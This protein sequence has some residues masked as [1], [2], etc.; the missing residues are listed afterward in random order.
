MHEGNTSIRFT[1][2]GSLN[3]EIE[4]ENDVSIFNSIANIVNKNDAN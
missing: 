3:D 1:N 2:E 4:E